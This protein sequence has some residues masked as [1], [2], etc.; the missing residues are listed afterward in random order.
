MNL[1]EVNLDNA[2]S[3]VVATFGSYSLQLG[4]RFLSE[5]P[6]LGSRVGSRVVLG[7]RPEDLSDASMERS[8][9]AG[10][11]LNVVP[12]LREDMGAEVLIH[13]DLGVPPFK[14]EAV[15][16]ATQ[17]EDTSADQPRALVVPFAARLTRG[18]LPGKERPSY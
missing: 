10:A 12:T 3:G 6:W 15:T 8:D 7:I 11:T 14:H 5:H 16:A 13:F 2:D 17:D 18:R 9:A 1:L 4:D